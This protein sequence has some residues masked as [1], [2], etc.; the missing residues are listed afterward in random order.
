[1]NNLKQAAVDKSRSYISCLSEAHK[2][3]FDNIRRYSAA[4]GFMYLYYL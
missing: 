4:H 1:M 3:L 2:M